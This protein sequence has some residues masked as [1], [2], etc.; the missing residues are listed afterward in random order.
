MELTNVANIDMPTAQAGIFP[1]PVVNWSDVLFRKKKEAPK[2]T[3]PA[4]R[5][6]KIKASINVSFI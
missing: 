2:I 5:E 4:I 1:A 6:K 3:F